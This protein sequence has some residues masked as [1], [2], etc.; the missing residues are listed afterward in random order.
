VVPSEHSTE[1]LIGALVK[2]LNRENGERYAERT[3]KQGP[4]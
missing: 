3:R 1:S 2:K 4:L